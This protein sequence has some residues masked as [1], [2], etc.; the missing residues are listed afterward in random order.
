MSFVHPHL[1]WLALLAP[2][3]AAGAA[4]V[5][6][7]RLDAAAQWAARGLW[8]RLL[9]GYDRRRLVLSVACLSVAVLGASLALARPR[10]GQSEEEVERRGVDIVFVLDSSLSM[11]ALDV[12]PSRMSAAKTVVRRLLGRLPGHR[13]A[14]VQAEGVGEVLAPLT[15]DASALD[16]LLDAIEPGSLPTPGTELAAALDAALGL[17]VEGDTKHR[18]LVLLSDGEDHGGALEPRLDE[19]GRSGVVV[20]TLGVGTP[21]GA[22]VPIPGG[23][24]GEYKTDSQGQVVVSRLHEETLERLARATGGVYLRTDSPAAD[25]S[26]VLERIEAMETATLATDTIEVHEERFQ[27]PLLAAV[28][29][30]LGYLAV[31]PF[32]PARRRGAS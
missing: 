15:V 24:S 23:R 18:V 32:K 12:R 1:L 31:S 29:A 28:L 20:H 13:V 7:R 21:D 2:L 17:F 5:W 6:R 19:L 27:V 16:L 11:A 25:L 22:P 4:W 10:W 30:L 26:P 14:L 3:V 9:A 8:D